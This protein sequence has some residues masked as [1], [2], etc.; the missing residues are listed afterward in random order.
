MEIASHP[1]ESQVASQNRFAYGFEEKNSAAISLKTL[2][3]DTVNLSFSGQSN[4]S[5]SA[6]ETLSQDG[7]VIHEFSTSAVAASKYS[8]SVQGS[9]NEA[10]M[11]AI[12]K[13]ADGI[14]PIAQSFFSNSDFSLESAA[15]SLAGSEIQSVEVKL[16][17]TITESFFEAGS[18]A[19]NP[20]PPTA[21]MG[22]NPQPPKPGEGIRNPEALVKAVVEAVFE[23]EGGKVAKD[24]PV[25]LHNLSDLVDYLRNKLSQF[26]E[27]LKSWAKNQAAATPATKPE[28]Q[29]EAK[30]DQESS[31]HPA[32]ISVYQNAHPNPEVES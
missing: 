12:R 25:L 6:S 22:A 30:N 3:G 15:Q 4:Y 5:K 19:E 26:R 17:Q 27:P 1:I 16:E 9:L 10:E 20:P 29:S 8:M 24:K 14:T 7:T 28:P 2:E 31:D 11:E 32:D 23:K 13:I 21:T 18:Q